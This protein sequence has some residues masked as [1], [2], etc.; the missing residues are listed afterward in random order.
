MKL[1]LNYN[2]IDKQQKCNRNVILQFYNIIKEFKQCIRN[3]LIEKSRSIDF[4]GML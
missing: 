3:W 1:K 4:R 2:E